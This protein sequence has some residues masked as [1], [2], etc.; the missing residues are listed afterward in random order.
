MQGK[1]RLH[2][3]RLMATGYCAGSLPLRF[4]MHCMRRKTGG[5]SGT[6]AELQSTGADLS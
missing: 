1:A 3:R 2:L 5:W 6:S 4:H